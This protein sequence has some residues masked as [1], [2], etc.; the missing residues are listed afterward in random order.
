MPTSKAG[1]Q[2]VWLPKEASLAS[3]AINTSL[4]RLARRFR[5]FLFISLTPVHQNIPSNLDPISA[6]K[7]RRADNGG[8]SLVW[9]QGQ[10]DISKV[11]FRY[12]ASLKQVV[13]AYL[14]FVM[15]LW[16]SLAVLCTMGR[17]VCRF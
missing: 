7:I 4:F 2:A 1:R 9:F 11:V 16:Q 10:R 6:V 13:C 17:C 15:I 5:L 14:W 12:Q 8:Q 3:R